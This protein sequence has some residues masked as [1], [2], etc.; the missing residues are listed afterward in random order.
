MNNP[1]RQLRVILSVLGLVC[2][3]FSLALTFFA[4]STWWNWALLLLALAFLLIS[5]RSQ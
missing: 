3:A 4:P 2:V 1:N 5:R